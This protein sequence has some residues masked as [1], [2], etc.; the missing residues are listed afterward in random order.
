[1]ENIVQR[2]A[3]HHESTRDDVRGQDPEA[4]LHP[5]LHD[6]TAE[7]K[8]KKRNAIGTNVVIAVGAGA[9]VAVGIAVGNEIE[10]RRRNTRRAKRTR[11]KRVMQ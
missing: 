9:R 3:H 8:E 7:T 10:R 6:D 2:R 5:T 1:V 11:T 4:W